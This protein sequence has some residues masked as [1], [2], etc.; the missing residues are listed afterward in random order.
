MGKWVNESIWE[1]KCE[2]RGKFER[3]LSN[4]ELCK[5]LPVEKSPKYLW[6]L[7]CCNE[8]LSVRSQDTS[9]CTTLFPCKRKSLENKMK[10][11][12]RHGQKVSVILTQKLPSFHSKTTQHRTF[13]TLRLF[14]PASTI[15]YKIFRHNFHLFPEIIRVLFTF[16]TFLPGVKLKTSSKHYAAIVGGFISFFFMYIF[17]INF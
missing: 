15:N 17:E 8:N 10:I 9:S 14:H 13:F 12:Q 7:N 3:K 6:K 2:N 5:V 16:F 4:I 11:D 1:I